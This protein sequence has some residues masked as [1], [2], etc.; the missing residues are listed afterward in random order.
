MRPAIVAGLA[1]L[2][3]AAMA[4]GMYKWVDEKGITHY[5]E[6]P[7]DDPKKATK[8]DIKPN[9]P[10]QGQQ[11][12]WRAKE[13]DSRTQNVQKIQED[14]AKAEQQA[15]VAE[16]R[17]IICQQAVRQNAYYQQQVPVFTVDDK[18]DRH[19]AEDN[20]RA[21]KIADAQEVMRKNCD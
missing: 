10:P 12:D 3:F 15:K 18:G 21:K 11:Y 8:I 1:F 16:Q 14:R 6:S 7:P 17:K 19:Y 5:S 9:G 13:L 2:S 4:E 20:E